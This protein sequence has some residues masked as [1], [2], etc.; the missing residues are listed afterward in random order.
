V[1]D[2]TAL[3][4]AFGRFLLSDDDGV[5]AAIESTP[6]LGAHDRLSIYASGYL[7]RLLEALRNDYPVVLGVL[8]ADVFASLGAAYIAARPSTSFTLRDFGGGLTAFIAQ[9][10][11]LAERE[12]VAELAAFER[13][14]VEAFDAVDA[15]PLD[16][17]ELAVVAGT[18]WPHLRFDVHPSVQECVITFNTLPVWEAVK[19]QRPAPAP[20]P[21][22][23]PVAALVWR[24]GL[25]TVFRSL[26]ADEHAVWRKLAAGEDFA[27]LCDTLTAWLSPDQVPLRAA[28]L[29]R[30]WLAEGLIAGLAAD[31]QPQ[32]R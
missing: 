21:L 32:C 28:T 11:G 31:L 3:Q 9:H 30:G 4:H 1:K 27:T 5:A 19:A 26:C 22:Q 13:A 24:Q 8:G 10:S 23:M 12:F 29:L 6:R 25:T 18:A 7:A 15:A 2:L 20:L 14:F 16:V 17:A